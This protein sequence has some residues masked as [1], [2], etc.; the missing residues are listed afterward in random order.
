MNKEDYAGAIRECDD[1]L[2]LDHTNF[3]GYR[4][5]GE[6]HM[7]LWERTKEEDE[8]LAAKRD[9]EMAGKYVHAMYP[10]KNGRVSEDAE[11]KIADL[12]SRFEKLYTK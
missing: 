7:T 9:F 12:E 4:I 3:D 10:G 1:I 5:R 2:R 8:R 11:S 6:C